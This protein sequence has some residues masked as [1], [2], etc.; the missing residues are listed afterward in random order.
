[1]GK[2]RVAAFQAH[3][4]W[5]DSTA[6]TNTILGAIED[7][8]E[9][10]VK[11]LAFPEAF[12]PGYPFWVLL[13]GVDR[14]G[15]ERGNEAFAAYLD[16]AVELS[17]PELEEITKA[18]QDH[19][20]FIYLGIAERKA[21]SVHATLVAIDPELGVVGSHRK[22]M[23]TYGERTVWAAGDGHGL[24]VHQ[25]SGWKIGGL[26]CWENWMPLPRQALYAQGEQLHVA[27]W[28]GSS[29]MTQEI[30]R[31]IAQEGRVFV[32]VAS[33]L[34]SHEDVPSDFPYYDLI[35]D[36]PKGFLNG[37]S[38]IASPDGTW[39]IGPVADEDRLL[40]ADID[41]ESVRHAKHTLDV[42]GHYARPDVF[43]LRVNRRRLQVAAM[44]AEE[45]RQSA[46][47]G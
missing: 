9:Q 39:Q 3:P 38:C 6:T 44:D 15:G 42:G 14:F 7:A 34:L 35:A 23:P 4:V 19:G 26:N 5:L 24:E 30:P 41:L 2:L 10:E 31:F 25:Y 16:A 43:D 33:G 13:G 11:L 8:A 28:P 20:I 37:G 18:A 32:I 1:M 27:A 17:G 12:L 29:A 40:V 21:N 47:A 22:L 36:K 45:R 46:E